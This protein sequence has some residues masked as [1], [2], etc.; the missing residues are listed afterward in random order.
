MRLHIIRHADPD[1]PNRTITPAGHR[2]A[3]ALAERWR[4]RG[5]DRLYAS[6]FGRAR[7]TAQYTADALEIPV[8]IEDWIAELE[9]PGLKIAE[10]VCRG[11]M[12]W[13]AHGEI[14]RA[15]PEAARRSEHW[16]KPPLNA[17]AVRDAVLRVR[18]GSDAFLARLGYRRDGGI[19]RVERSNRDRVA[20]VCHGGSGLVWLAHLL[21]LP[22]SLAWAGFWLAP[23]SVT[24]ILMDERSA[25]TAVP[26][27]LGVGDV[28][29]LHAAG[30]PVQPAG[31]KA[32]FD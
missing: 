21:E 13:D 25:G 1:Y 11:L 29:H 6:P 24:T 26:R 4:P 7:D 10:G 23:T 32:N 16:L 31:I 27:A 9:G 30:L 3:A 15:D 18:S 8:G 19:Y 17:H 14:I 5:L 28:S 20:V 22:L 2:E 12:V